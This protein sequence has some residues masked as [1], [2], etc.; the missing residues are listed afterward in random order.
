MTL[1]YCGSRTTYTRPLPLWTTGVPFT[2]CLIALVEHRSKW[3]GQTPL[4][5]SVT[6]VTRLR[7]KAMTNSNYTIYRAGRGRRH[8]PSERQ[9]FH[10]KAHDVLK[11]TRKRNKNSILERFLSHE[12]YRTD[13]PKIIASN[14][15]RSLP[16][17]SPTLQLRKKGKG[18][19]NIA[20]F[21]RDLAN[22]LREREELTWKQSKRK[23]AKYGKLPNKTPQYP[24]TSHQRDASDRD[25]KFLRDGKWPK[26]M[27]GS[28]AQGHQKRD[29]HQIMD[30]QAQAPGS[31]TQRRSASS[32]KVRYLEQELQ[33]QQ[34]E[35]SNRDRDDQNSCRT[36]FI[37]SINFNI[38]EHEFC[39]IRRTCDCC[40]T[41]NVAGISSASGTTCS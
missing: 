35:Y 6:K 3:I 2:A 26:D 31:P 8:G 30:P 33:H 13:G 32:G 16:Q 9:T 17:I 10:I 21:Q 7:Q 20:S 23:S 40:A 28:K 1:F 5:Q 27:S 37:F 19:E 29:F 15:T 38:A 41:R 14:W 18:I 24:S 25:S 22:A 36:H 39:S 11:G 4:L 34:F 12:R